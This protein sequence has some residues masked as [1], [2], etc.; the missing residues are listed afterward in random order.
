MG[1]VTAGLDRSL[2]YQGGKGF[3]LSRLANFCF[4]VDA[5]EVEHIAQ[6]LFGFA[7]G[8][9]NAE[10]LC[11]IVIECAHC[12][13]INGEKY[14]KH[15]VFYILRVT[16]RTNFRVLPTPESKKVTVLVT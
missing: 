8:L 10:Q 13:W 16:G 4:V 2:P 14:F 5:A 6:C 15:D 12:L 11:F 7:H 3:R 9:E 1:S